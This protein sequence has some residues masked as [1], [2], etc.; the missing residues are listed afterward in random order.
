MFPDVPEPS[1]ELSAASSY[2][3][4]TSSNITSTEAGISKKLSKGKS[5]TFD[6][7]KPKKV[8]I[9][10]AKKYP[11]WQEKYIDLVREAFDAINI[12][13]NDKEL[14]PKVA[15]YGEMKKAMPFVQ[16]LKQRLVQSREDPETVFERKLPFDE[17]AV[18][19]EMSAGL[20][21]TTGC[22]EIDI[23]AVDEG[24]KSGEV[25]GTGEKVG[26]LQAENAIPGQPTFRF[27]NIA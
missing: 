17:F 25:V 11:S 16:N 8:T 14:K 2:V 1:P 27:V 4:T 5:S 18:L 21:R 7:K 15:Q 19:R 3:R 6:P 10:A 9:Y 22:Q 13:V 20:K 26:D 23:V 12:S 24:G